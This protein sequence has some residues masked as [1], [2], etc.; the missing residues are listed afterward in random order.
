MTI[1][2]TQANGVWTYD[3]PEQTSLVFD[4]LSLTGWDMTGFDVWITT[5]QHWK[6]H[7]KKQQNL[8]ELR[9]RLTHAYRQHFANNELLTVYAEL[10][11]SEAYR[12]AAVMKGIPLE[13][14][15]NKQSLKQ[16]ARRTGKTALDVYQKRDILRRWNNAFTTYGLR[17]SLAREFEVSEDTISRVVKAAN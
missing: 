6:K 1:G 2:L 11:L 5:P 4:I 8:I 15:A 7:P 12:T 14:A 13:I 16:A 10:L 3:D 9:G 17:K